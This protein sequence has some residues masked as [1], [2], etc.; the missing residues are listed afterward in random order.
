GPP[1][2]GFSRTPVILR[3]GPPV[4]ARNPGAPVGRA[5]CPP[6]GSLW[7][8]RDLQPSPPR[9]G[10]LPAGLADAPRY[11]SWPGGSPQRP[12]TPPPCPPP[13]VGPPA[14][15]PAPLGAETAER[16]PPPPRGQ[17]PRRE[18]EQQRA[19]PIASSLPSGDACSPADPQ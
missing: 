19:G 1:V 16:M 17:P 12:P 18:S 5:V 15:L 3:R 13:G 7:F 4:A 9:S 2:K 10:S 14:P 8:D 6:A 11:P